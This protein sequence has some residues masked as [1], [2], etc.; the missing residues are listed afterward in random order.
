MLFHV[1]NICEPKHTD[2]LKKRKKVACCLPILYIYNFIFLI[3]IF[4]VL[5]ICMG[6]WGVGGGVVVVVFVVVLLV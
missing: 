4:V 5:F 6:V 3:M 1:I 2:T